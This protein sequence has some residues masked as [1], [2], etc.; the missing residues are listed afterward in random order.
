MTGMSRPS[1]RVFTTERSAAPCRRRRA[2]GWRACNARRAAPD[3]WR[4]VASSS[5]EDTGLQRRNLAET[6]THNACERDETEWRII[7]SETWKFCRGGG[8][9]PMPW[10]RG[11]SFFP[12]KYAPKCSSRAMSCGQP[13]FRSAPLR[14]EMRQREGQTSSNLCFE[15]VDTYQRR[16]RDRRPS[17]RREGSHL[18]RSRIPG[19]SQVPWTDALIPASGGGRRDS[20]D[21]REDE[22]A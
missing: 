9:S 11:Q 20:R 8:C 6:G 3:A 22:L 12:S 18:D 4:L 17:L 21:R 2:E 1:T 13:R 5:V 15:Q 7:N 19:L 10:T 16:H 14:T